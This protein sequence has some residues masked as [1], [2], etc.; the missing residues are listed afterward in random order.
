MNIR[1][2]DE[3]AI[4]TPPTRSISC[5]LLT[6]AIPQQS[7]LTSTVS[8]EFD[9]ADICMRDSYADDAVLLP[10][11]TRVWTSR[12]NI[13]PIQAKY[14]NR[15]TGPSRSDSVFDDNE[16]EDRA[17]DSAACPLSSPNVVAQ[18]QNM[19]SNSRKMSSETSLQKNNQANGSNAAHRNKNEAN[20]MSLPF[21]DGE[22]YENIVIRSLFNQLESKQDE[23]SKL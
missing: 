19:P 20:L 4:F 15:G 14:V 18:E 23:F 1:D 9:G 5:E 17:S 16:N 21:S 22:S 8:S 3:D 12:Y 10:R 7:S 11:D 2:K 6:D 13:H